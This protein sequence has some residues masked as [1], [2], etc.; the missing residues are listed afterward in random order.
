[1][2]KDNTINV[3]FVNTRTY[4]NS[5]DNDGMDNDPISDLWHRLR[6]ATQDIPERKRSGFLEKVCGVRQASVSRWRTGENVLSLRHAKAISEATGYCVQYLLEG[7]G[8][9][10]WQPSNE[11]IAAIFALLDELDDETREEVL[12]YAEFRAARTRRNKAP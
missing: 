4:F 9:K 8:P 6:E 10:R 5:G 2:T 7:T 3:S 1:M 11:D 12:Q